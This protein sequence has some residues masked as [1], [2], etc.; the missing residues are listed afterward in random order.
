[1]HVLGLEVQAIGK[2]LLVGLVA[3]AGL[4]LLFSLGIRAMAWG[5]GGDAEASAPGRVAVAHPL[6]RVL[7]AAC[8]LVV[9]ACVGLGITF[10]VASG[11]GKA[12]SF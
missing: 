12:L 9:L 2:I 4:P 3:G 1:M 10:I 11:F 8:F 6:G 7:G 5:T